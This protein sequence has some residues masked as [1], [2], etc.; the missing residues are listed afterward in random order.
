MYSMRGGPRSHQP[1]L[2]SLMHSFVLRLGGTL[3]IIMDNVYVNSRKRLH[4]LTRQTPPHPPSTAP[5]TK[6]R[7]THQ[8]PPHPPSYIFGRLLLCFLDVSVF[9]QQPPSP[10]GG[11]AATASKVG[12]LKKRCLLIFSQQR[13]IGVCWYL[14][15]SVLP[16]L[17]AFLV[18][19]CNSHFW[20]RVIFG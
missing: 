9:R 10:S 4:R 8:A 16:R 5:P 15:G 19:D 17:H 2:G 14:V 12:K 11:N 20:M 13:N 7:P 18:H 6:H 1:G 3:I